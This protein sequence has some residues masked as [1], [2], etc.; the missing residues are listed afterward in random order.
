MRAEPWP[1]VSII[2]LITKYGPLFINSKK[3]E[4]IS[5]SYLWSALFWPQMHPCKWNLCIMEWRELSV[6]THIHDDKR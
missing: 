4:H 5:E 3:Q 2:K 1:A 6:K